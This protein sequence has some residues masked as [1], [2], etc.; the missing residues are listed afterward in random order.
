MKILIAEDDTI[1]GRDLEKNLR[2]WGYD[3]VKKERTR[4]DLPGKVYL[5]R[6]RYV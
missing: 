1:S 3:V 5:N 6:E 4:P 2:E